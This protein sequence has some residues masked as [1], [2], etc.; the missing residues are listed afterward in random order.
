MDDAVACNAQPGCGIA[1]GRGRERERGERGGEMIGCGAENVGD[2]AGSING[3]VLFCCVFPAGENRKGN[4]R[5]CS[6]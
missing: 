2:C 3:F 6:L 5:D 1:S 4:D